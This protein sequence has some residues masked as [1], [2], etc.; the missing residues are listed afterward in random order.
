[1]DIDFV[2][3]VVYV[4]GTALEE[5]YINDLTY[6][7]EG[8]RFPL[9]VPEGSVFLMGDNRNMS[10]DSRDTRIGTVDTRYLIG[11]AFFLA[12]P[13]ETVGTGQRDFGRI[14]SLKRG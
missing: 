1:M 3:G 5:P 4:D 11:R 13:G 6:T 8:T 7:D 12:F 14:G 10:T 9:T 2:S